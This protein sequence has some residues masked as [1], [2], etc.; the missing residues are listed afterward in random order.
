MK[1]DPT[2]KY[3]SIRDL[4]ISDKKV[5]VRVDFNVP[6]DN[7]EVSSDVRIRK[8]LPTIEY[9]KDG[10]AKVILMSHLGR[11]GGKEVPELR[12]DPVADSLSHLLGDPVKKM[13]DCI[14][15]E[16]LE[17]SQ[18]L[19]QG[20][21]MLLE[22]TRFHEGEKKNSR[23]FARSLSKVGDMFV[24]DAFGTVHRKHASTYGVAEFLESAAGLLVL[25]EIKG[26]SPALEDPKHP[27]IAILGGK[28]ASSKIGALRDMME[29]VDI[30]LIGGALAFT[31]L[32][33]KGYMVGDS[34]V[35]NSMVDEVRDFLEEAKEN[36]LE[37]VLPIDAKIAKEFSEEGEI[38][39]TRAEKIPPG[40]MGLDIGPATIKKFSEEID[41]AEMVVWA[42]PLG[43]FELE[44]FREGTREIAETLAEAS[45][46]RI[47]GGGET[48]AA[49]SKLGLAEKMDH[50]STGGGAC[51]NYLRGKEL[52]ALEILKHHLD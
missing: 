21:V 17:A 13:D 29:R 28:K 36:N 22:N 12:M 33:A 14:G 15:E 4:E 46:Y 19:E 1:I 40:W 43:G 39:I 38:K 35:D 26:L 3:N 50:V 52:P 2:S 32:N 31:F 5:L 20:E 10:G 24:N 6:L 8:A 30:F 9:L 49:V 25:E 51:L 45:S 44:T 27:F 23:D 48:G 37:V 41:R 11:P 47:I 42:G 34:V 18:A 16:V 7:G